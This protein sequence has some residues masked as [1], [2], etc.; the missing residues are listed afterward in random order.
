LLH[1]PARQPGKSR[2]DVLLYEVD[3]GIRRQGEPKPKR[4]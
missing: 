4:G 1:M 2:L 3:A